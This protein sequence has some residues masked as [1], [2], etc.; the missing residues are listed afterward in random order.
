MQNEKEKT[1][2]EASY[3][4]PQANNG[5]VLLNHLTFV[6]LENFEAFFS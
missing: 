5:I 1:D 4:S 2:L 3:S 6:S